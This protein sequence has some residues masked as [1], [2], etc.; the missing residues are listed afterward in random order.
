MPKNWFQSTRLLISFRLI[1]NMSMILANIKIRVLE[2][3]K[4]S[5]RGHIGGQEGPNAQKL[6][7]LNS[8]THELS[9]DTPHAYST[10]KNEI[11]ILGGLRTFSRP[12]QGVRGVGEFFQY[13]SAMQ[14]LQTF[15]F[16][17]R[18]CLYLLHDSQKLASQVAPKTVVILLLL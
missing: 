15:R 7:P 14:E 18:T 6:V 9:N 12:L 11:P 13:F 17:G 3:Y 1:P 8:P 2:A 5:I 4:G 10:S 16:V